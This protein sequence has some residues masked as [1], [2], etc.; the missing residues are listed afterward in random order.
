MR[1]AA[2][3]ELE[4]AMAAAAMEKRER[5]RFMVFCEV[6]GLEA[7]ELTICERLA[8]VFAKVILMCYTRF[9]VGG[10]RVDSGMRGEVSGKSLVRPSQMGVDSRGKW[11]GARR[12]G[13]SRLLWA[14]FS[15]LRLWH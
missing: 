2:L 4:S 9:S 14:G 11:S 10:L 12:R 3:A 5:N 6:W 8:T 15:S 1:V 13:T 7:D